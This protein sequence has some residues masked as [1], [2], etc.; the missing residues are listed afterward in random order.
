MTHAVVTGGAGMLGSRLA[1]E[2]LA[3]GSLGAA[4]EQPRALSRRTSPPTTG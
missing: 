2:L 4:G 3:S 1:R